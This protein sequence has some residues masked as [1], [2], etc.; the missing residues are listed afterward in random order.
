[1]SNFK[2]VSTN[3]LNFETKPIKIFHR[4]VRAFT[5]ITTDDEEEADA[6]IELYK[7]DPEKI[8]NNVPNTKIVDVS[9][10]QVK[11]DFGAKITTLNIN[12]IFNNYKSNQYNIHLVDSYGEDADTCLL[13]NEKIPCKF[14][15]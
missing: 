6:L 5:F 10:I 4:L 8:K 9:K 1:M 13:T 14:T 3:Q 2:K 12:Y 11:N 15:I 7:S